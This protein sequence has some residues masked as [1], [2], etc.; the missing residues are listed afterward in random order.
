MHPQDEIR[1]AKLEIL[2]NHESHELHES[3]QPSLLFNSCYSCNSWFLSLWVGFRI[4]ILGWLFLATWCAPARADGGSVRLSERKG[5]YRIT[6]F[7][8]PSP[9]RAGPVDISVLVQDAMTGQPLTQARVSVRMIKIGQP[10]L[11]NA[12]TQEAATNKLLHAAQFELPA[13]GRWELEVRVEGSQGSAALACE[14]EAAERLPRWHSLWPWI[15]WPAVAI[16]L[17]CTHELFARRKFGKM[18]GMPPVAQAGYKPR[19]I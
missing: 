7:S 9:F 10:T 16:A 13:P 2:R 6:V 1:N 18:G 14:V 3:I 15:G 19:T 12:A 17:F 11:E 5:G 8:A 4:W